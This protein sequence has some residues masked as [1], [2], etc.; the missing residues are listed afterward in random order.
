M[1]VRLEWDQKPEQ[2]ER[3]VLPFQTVET[4][5]ESRAT[6]ERDSGTL[7]G[8]SAAGSDMTRNM[9]IWGDNKLVASSLLREYAGSVRLVYIDPP[10]D[11]G[12]DFSYRV[13]IGD[14]SVTKLPSILEEHAYRDT[15]SGGRSSYL[16]MMYER[17]VLL[18]DLLAADGSLYLHC[19]PNVSHYLKVLCDEVFGADRARAEIVWKRV[20]GH[21]D[22]KKWSPVHEIIFHYSKGT[23]YVWHPPRESLGLEYSTT[24]YVHDDG[25]GRGPYRL[26]NLT[27]PNPRPNMTYEW[28]GYPPPAKGWRY[29]LV[30]MTELDLDGRIDKPGDKKRRPQLKRYLSENEGHLVDDVWTDVPPVNSQALERTGYE[31]QKPLALLERIILASSDPGDIVADVFCGSGT[32]LVAAEQLGRHWI[33]CDLGRFAIH[34]TRKRLL[35]VAD[36]K[37]FDIKNLGAY[38][39]QRWQESTASGAVRGYLDTILAFYQAEPIEGFIHLHGRKADRLVHVGATD[40]PITMDEAEEVMDEMADNGVQACDLLGWEWEMGLH[41][42]ISEQAR[43]RGLVLRPLQIPRE[44]MERRVTEADV[45]R[46]FELA[47]V[48]FEVRRQ[49]REACVVLSDFIIPSEDLIPV[50][51]RDQISV[52]SDLIDYWSVDFDYRDDTFHNQWQT[53]RTREEAKLATQSGWHSYPEAGRYTIVVKVIDIFGNDTTKLA[54]VHIR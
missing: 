24:K 49:Q 52:W 14:S 34:T 17:I 39:R 28:K 8:S 47:F 41:D 31:T 21:G 48:D 1:A 46:F 42:T 11:T 18:Y 3:L 33:G 53:Y 54:E 13:G 10:F 50:H 9:L 27:S 6:R 38:E 2:I 36:C 19:A 43:R 15:W 20:S 40:A 25:D 51:V 26:D 35:N 5:N 44:V 30:T 45:V 29:S 12:T 32:T 7:F 37:P 4:I 23:S 22:A 16:Q